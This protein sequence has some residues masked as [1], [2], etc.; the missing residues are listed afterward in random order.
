MA[1]VKNAIFVEINQR[2]LPYLEIFLKSLFRFYP[3]CPDLFVYHTDLN[4][5][6]LRRLRKYPAVKTVCLE[7]TDFTS[8]PSMATHRPKFADPKIS[9]ARFLIWTDKM[10]DYENVVHL[11]ADLL[12]LGRFDDLFAQDRFTIFAETYQAEDSLFYNSKNP[13]LVRLLDEDGIRLP[14]TVANCGVF[15]VPRKDRSSEDFET[16]GYLLKRYSN[17]IKWSDQSIINLWMAKKGICVAEG[18]QFNFQHRLITKPGR[19]DG[20]REAQIFHFNGVDLIYRLFLVRCASFLCRLPYG[21][22][23][24]RFVYRTTD[25]L[26]RLWRSRDKWSRAYR[27]AGQQVPRVD[28]NPV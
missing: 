14:V 13:D 27:R 23:I 8:G 3:D 12:I 24:Y 18:N 6:Q 7:E 11:D 2:F 1:S 28:L 17:Y 4:E 10:K 5:T 16:L 9:Y 19:V 21:W 26:L 20:L 22:N 15:V 25:D